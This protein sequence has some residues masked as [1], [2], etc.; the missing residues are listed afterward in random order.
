[1]KLEI[2]KDKYLNC[3]IVWECH[4]NYKI[5]RFHGKTKE[6]CEKQLKKIKRKRSK[7]NGNK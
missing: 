5:D 6:E 7:R 1:M 3:W 4:R 2:E